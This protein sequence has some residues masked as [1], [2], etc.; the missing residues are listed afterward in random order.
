MAKAKKGAKALPT[1]I[2]LIVDRSGS[3]GHIAQEAS[4]AINSYL[5][6][7]AKLDGDCTVILADFDGQDP[8]RLVHDGDLKAR[9]PYSMAPR[10]MTP[11]NDA[12]GRGIALT[13]ERSAKADKVIV[14][15]VTDGGENSSREYTSGQITNLIKAKEA[16]GWGFVFLATDQAAWHAADVYVGTQMV[17][18]MTRSAGTGRAYGSTM[19]YASANT[20]AFRSGEV[21]VAAVAAVVD[22]DGNITAEA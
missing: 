12:I 3:M 13:A 9:T 2:T 1:H 4:A 15:I 16:E 14:V 19:S 5:H 10:G 8:F 7:Q 22:A 11:L 17:N 18:N 6:E 20:K 21:A